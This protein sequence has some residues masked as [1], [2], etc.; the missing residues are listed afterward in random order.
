VEEKKL[1]P[2]DIGELVTDVLVEHFPEVV[3]TKF[4]AEMEDKLDDVASG[5]RSR[6]EVLDAFYGPYAKHLKLKEKE[7]TK[8]EL[9]E[10]QTDIECPQCKQGKLVIKVGRFGRFYACSR[11]PDCDYTDKMASNN[12]PAAEPVE[13][14]EKCPTC[15][16]PLVRRVGK[17]GPFVGCSDFPN[18]K[19]V[20]Q[21]Q[22]LLDVKCPLCGN[23]LVEKRTR[24][25]KSFWGCSTYPKCDF[26]TWND[27]KTT[28][29]S[30][31]EYEKNKAKREAKN[32]EKKSKSRNQKSD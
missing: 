4:T 7:L 6:E 21:K 31:E 27:P 32:Q 15:G 16:K 28:P 19:Y 22:E 10:E 30:I 18:C 9:T 2:S 13:T 17:Y 12:K 14:G 20:E 29:P 23:P 11:Y 26:G 25:R 5:K 8:K 24:F 1:V 3:D